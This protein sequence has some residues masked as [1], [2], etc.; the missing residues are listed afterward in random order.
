LTRV[1]PRLDE[2]TLLLP[3]HDYNGLSE[4]LLGSEKRTNEHLQ[5][6]SRDE[7]VAWLSAAAEPAPAWMVETLRANNAG[8]VDPS[9]CLA[10]PGAASD[11]AV[12]P[13]PRVP[14]LS[15]DEVRRRLESE[16]PGLL[17]LDVRQG[18]EYTGE[19][20]HVPGAVLVPLPELRARL[21]EIHGRREGTVIT[22]CRS[23]NRS[24]RAA[25]ILRDAGFRGV[26]NMT[27]GTL[28]WRER[29][30]PVER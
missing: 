16:G 15:A 26:W 9:L 24:A 2:S 14:Q 22:I 11:C 18:E 29:G 28:A 10:P 19:L 8:P 30:F 4:A 27:G 23:G 12:G 7:Y 20:G 13:G 21:H 5:D 6:R 1:I 25:A 3:G 17:L